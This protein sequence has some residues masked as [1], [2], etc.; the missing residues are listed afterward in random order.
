[1]SFYGR[2]AGTALAAA[3][4]ELRREGSPELDIAEELAVARIIADR[5]VQA[6]EACCLDPEGSKR[7]TPELKAMA[8]AAAKEALS[9][10]AGLAERLAKIRAVS[11][12]FVSAEDVKLVADVAAKAV[13]RVLSGRGIPLDVMDEVHRELVSMRLPQHGQVRIVV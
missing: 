10:V 13:E 2:K 11:S 1:M 8:T 3:L 7:T 6:F 5:S 4:D 9:H 12:A